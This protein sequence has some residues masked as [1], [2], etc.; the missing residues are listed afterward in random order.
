MA[1]I[2]FYLLPKISVDLNVSMFVWKQKKTGNIYVAP[3]LHFLWNLPCNCLTAMRGIV[4]NKND[5]VC[6]IHV[7]INFSFY[8]LYVGVGDFCCK[9]LIASAGH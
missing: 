5:L 3:S 1:L 2:S 6:S 8:L 4:L 7:Y 9:I